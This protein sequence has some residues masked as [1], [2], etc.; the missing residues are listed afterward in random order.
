MTENNNKSLEDLKQYALDHPTEFFIETFNETVEFLKSEFELSDDRE[1]IV[2]TSWVFASHL[3]FSWVVYA[4]LHFLGSK[5]CGKSRAQETLYLLS[6]NSKNGVFASPASLFRG[7]KADDKFHT[8]FIDE[9]S[10]SNIKS[11]LT[12]AI[13]QILNV[14]YK[15]GGSIPRCVKETENGEDFSVKDYE[16][17]GFKCLAGTLPLDFVS[18]LQSRCVTIRMRKTRRRFPIRINKEK[19]E[20][21]KSKIDVWSHLYVD[22]EELKITDVIE[23]KLFNLSG[24]DGR[25]VELFASLYIVTP[26]PHKPIIEEYLKDSGTLEIEE[27]LASWEYEI[28]SA[29]L[30]VPLTSNWFKTKDVAEKV[31]FEKN[32]NEKVKT[33]SVGRQIKQFGF[34]PHHTNQARGWLWDEKLVTKLKERYP[35]EEESTIQKK[36]EKILEYLSLGTEKSQEEIVKNTEIPF[37]EVLKLLEQLLK[38]GKIQQGSDPFK[39]VIVRGLNQ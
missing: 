38:E 10:M 16:V 20:A 28:F 37:E 13:L 24:Y 8:L 35:I 4:Y 17:D 19:A 18:T 7:I 22:K 23:Q 31:N 2:L 21:L 30:K 26:D 6:F 39:Y 27:E 9:F 5:K 25:L 33:R 14:G 11:E 36:L 29:I 1:Y 12:Q 15:K 32:E 3:P 34:K